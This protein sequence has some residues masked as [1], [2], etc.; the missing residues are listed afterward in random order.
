MGKMNHRNVLHLYEVFESQNSIYLVLD[1]LRGGELLQSLKKERSFLGEVDRAIIMKNLLLGLSHIHEKG[2]MHR[3]LKP[4][5]IMLREPNSFNDIVIV[6]F[7]LSSRTNI[8]A[9]NMLFKKCG[10]PGF[11]APEVFECKDNR[12]CYNE[13]CDVFSAG[14]IFYIL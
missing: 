3:D 11:V 4:E 5:N 2:V 10:T 9:K 13:K 14:V 12:T 6:D 1:L 8:D 7:G